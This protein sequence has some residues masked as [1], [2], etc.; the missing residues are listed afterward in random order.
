[1]VLNLGC[2]LEPPGAIPKASLPPDTSKTSEIQ[3]SVERGPRCRY[4]PGLPSDCQWAV[5]VRTSP[6]PFFSWGAPT[7]PTRPSHPASTPGIGEPVYL[8]GTV[9]SSAHWT[10]RLPLFQSPSTSLSG[11]TGW[12]SPPPAL[13]TSLRVP[14]ATPLGP[15]H[16]DE[17]QECPAAVDTFMW[18]SYYGMSKTC[19]G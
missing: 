13:A 12:W 1:M 9:P 19:V 18:M 8:F 3:V 4:F 16:R 17:T 10:Y 11:L 15:L 14:V 5:E 6:H 2:T 7:H